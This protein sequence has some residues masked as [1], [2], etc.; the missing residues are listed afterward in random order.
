MA[1]GPAMCRGGGVLFHC[2]CR[3]AVCTAGPNTKRCCMQLRSLPALS[4]FVDLKTD[5]GGYREATRGK[6]TAGHRRRAEIHEF[7]LF[8]RLYTRTKWLHA[9][10]FRAHV[11]EWLRGRSQVPMRQR[12]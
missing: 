10:N 1:V 8:W 4:F 6:K 9:R 7:P 11:P 3:G 2:G 12:S 5:R